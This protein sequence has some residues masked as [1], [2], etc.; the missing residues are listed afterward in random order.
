MYSMDKKEKEQLAE[1]AAFLDKVTSFEKSHQENLKLQN[2][3]IAEIKSIQDNI[4][5][6]NN[7]DLKGKIKLLHQQSTEECEYQKGVEENITALKDA[8]EQASTGDDFAFEEKMRDLH[9]E[10]NRSLQHQIE[11][12]TQIDEMKKMYELDQIN[13]E[14][15]KSDETALKNLEVI[16]K[17]HNRALLKQKQMVNDI[18]LIQMNILSE[19]QKDDKRIHQLEKL[20]ADNQKQ[21]ENQR[22]HDEKLDEL[23]EALDTMNT[24]CDIDFEEKM[25][26]V[27]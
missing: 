18:E 10:H 20:R 17:D 4:A 3:L 7:E 21:L 26:L 1:N 12:M 19:Q 22:H 24:E 25:R 16:K 2:N 13:E 11:M 9:Q 14:T 6:N 23:K 27:Q 5:M 8:L 15:T